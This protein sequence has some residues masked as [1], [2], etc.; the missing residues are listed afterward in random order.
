M[1]TLKS[2]SFS[3]QTVTPFNHKNSGVI[4]PKHSA[5]IVSKPPNAEASSV[6]LFTS[7]TS[8]MS[9]PSEQQQSVDILPIP[10]PSSMP[11]TTSPASVDPKKVCA[12]VSFSRFDIRSP[13]TKTE[14]GNKLQL[15]CKLSITWRNSHFRLL[16]PIQ[17]FKLDQNLMCIVLQ[18]LDYID[19]IT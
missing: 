11:S 2:A 19:I 6:S 15:L 1:S 16:V 10:G 13:L 17:T 3:S 4:I 9:K 7:N 12:L 8:E 18:T 5:A 14:K